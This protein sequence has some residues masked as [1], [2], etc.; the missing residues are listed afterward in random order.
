MQEQEGPYVEKF[1][2]IVDEWNNKMIAKKQ[3]KMPN[4]DKFYKADGTLE[5]AQANVGNLLHN[6]RT[7]EDSLKELIRRNRWD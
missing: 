5:K 2:T 7:V 6:H 3:A 1:G 4:K